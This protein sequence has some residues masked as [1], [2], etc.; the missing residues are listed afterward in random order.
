MTKE[1]YYGNMY[2]Q[3]SIWDEEN[4]SQRKAG[5][6]RREIDHNVFKFILDQILKVLLRTIKSG[7]IQI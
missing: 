1:I 3:E 6:P 7:L 4:G 5:D 2:I